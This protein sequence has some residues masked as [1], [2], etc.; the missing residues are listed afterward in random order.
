MVWTIGTISVILYIAIGIVY[1]L[2]R[3]RNCYDLTEGNVSLTR[4]YHRNL[5]Q[6][7]KTQKKNVL[8]KAI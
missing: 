7:K 2:R 4:N 3:R 1:L 5:K 8:Y 6:K